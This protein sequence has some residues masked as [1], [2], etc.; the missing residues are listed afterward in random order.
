MRQG[1]YP[2]QLSHQ[3]MA[4]RTREGLASSVSRMAS[5]VV[6]IMAPSSVVAIM[7]PS[8]VVA[9]MAYASSSILV[10]VVVLTSS[11]VPP[12]TVARCAPASAASRHWARSSSGPVS[13]GQRGN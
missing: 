1:Q 4:R 12:T 9:T 8:S 5:S 10:I 2:S 3:V 13:G 11:V 6:A 7:T